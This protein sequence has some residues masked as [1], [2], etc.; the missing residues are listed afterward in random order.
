MGPNDDARRLGHP[1]PLHLLLW[2]FA[3][4]CWSSLAGVG[5]RWSVL[6][7]VGL[8]WPSWAVVAS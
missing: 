6:A 7:C 2:A 5:L 8:L 3:G 4:L 1:S